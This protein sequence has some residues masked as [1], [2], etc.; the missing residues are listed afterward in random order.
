MGWNL[1]NAGQRRVAPAA[2]H[3]PASAVSLYNSLRTANS[4][5]ELHPP[6]SQSKA[7]R[8]FETASAEM[9]K[10]PR[11]AMTESRQ[12]HR[13]APHQHGKEAPLF[14]EKR[15]CN[16]KAPGN[17]VGQPTSWVGQRVA[18]MQRNK[19]ARTNESREC[20]ARERT[21]VHGRKKNCP[22]ARVRTRE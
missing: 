6:S 11:R 13:T 10:S 4:P 8:R 1:P 17:W 3:C 15:A 16:I 20:S 7:D 18:R 2:Q 21:C 22:V 19:N 14:K 12:S 9:R 5:K